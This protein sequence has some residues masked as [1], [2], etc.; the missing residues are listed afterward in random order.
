MKVLITGAT[1][2]VG[3]GVLMEALQDVRITEVLVVA[4]R[5]SGYVHPK[6]TEI[7]VPDF[8]ELSALQGSLAGIDGCFFCLG[9]SS[10]G[11][12]K[13]TYEKMTYELT[14]HFA[15]NL[16]LE[17]PQASFFY[18]SGA[19]TDATEK[20]TLHWARVKGK[21]ENDLRTLGFQQ[22]HAMRPG[23]MKPTENQKYALKFYRYFGWLFPLMERWGKKSYCTLSTVGRCMIN[24]TEQ[25][26]GPDTLEVLD[27]RK[28]GA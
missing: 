8:F 15:K 17:S 25:K 26:N 9:I 27:I 14:L 24:L 4:R 7:L 13:P 2:M 11:V 20:S 23:M 16:V 1:G 18:I 10:L 22:V 21:T 12:D 6:L 19:G 28:Y 5:S 3:E